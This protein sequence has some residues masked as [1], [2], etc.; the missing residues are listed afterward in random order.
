[1]CPIV[2]I[3]GYNPFGL[4][5]TFLFFFE[6]ERDRL[7]EKERERERER[8]REREAGIFIMPL[9]ALKPT[10]KANSQLQKNPSKIPAFMPISLQNVRVKIRN[11]TRLHPVQL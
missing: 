4:C 3:K 11:A 7:R 10:S 1:M 6:R 2:S 9:Y 8:G 5:R